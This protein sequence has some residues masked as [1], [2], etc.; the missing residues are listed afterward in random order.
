[1]L[2]GGQRADA[3]HK[4]DL[5]ATTGNCAMKLLPG[6]VDHPMPNI[7]RSAGD[8]EAQLSKWLDSFPASSWRL[9]GRHKNILFGRL[10]LTMQQGR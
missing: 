6:T 7:A 2:A 8:P 5:A 9:A 3:G 10:N 4:L 1:V